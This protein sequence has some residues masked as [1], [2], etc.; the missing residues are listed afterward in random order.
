VGLLRGGDRGE[1]L[2][3]EL[4]DLLVGAAQRP[5]ADTVLTRSA[6]L[7]GLSMSVTPGIAPRRRTTSA[8]A[9]VTC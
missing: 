5:S 1:R 3:D 6:A 9:A 8:T 7:S 2:V 4:G